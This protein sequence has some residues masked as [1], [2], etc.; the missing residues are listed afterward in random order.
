MAT[1]KRPSVAPMRN[2]SAFLTPTIEATESLP[3]SQVPIEQITL[4]AQQPRR[5]FDPAKMAYLIESVREHG[6]LEPLI[7]RPIALNQ[8]ELLAGERRL[9]AAQALKLPQVPISSR[10][11]SDREAQQIALV[12]NLQRE[13]LN[14]IEETEAI[15]SLLALSLDVEQP[16]IIALL[17][18]VSNAQK[19]NLDLT[20][21]VFRQYEQIENLLQSIGRFTAQ[22]FRSSRLPLL[23]LPEEILTAL[24]Q[25]KLEYTKARAIAQVKDEA[26]RK[27]LLK[28]AVTKDLSLSAIKEEIAVVRAEE[29]G[30]AEGDPIDFKVRFD[31]IHRR[32]KRAKLW[33]DPKKRRRLEKMMG[34]LEALL[35]TG[36][37]QS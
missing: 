29:S 36:V 20:E 15:L 34:D 21:N 12:E 1:R 8:Y 14:P 13:D 24:R 18:Q 9:R 7:V 31:D 10:E 35:E 16:E 25:G 33:D 6:I 17:N 32:V 30:N 26:K 3:L 19:R 23:N 28:Q 27:K 22:S 2:V 4:P 11:F 5:Y 37:A